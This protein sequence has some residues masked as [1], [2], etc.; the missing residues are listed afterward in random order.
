M[1]PGTCIACARL[2][3]IV[4]LNRPFLY[5]FCLGFIN[6]LI[7][8]YL[9]K[10][11]QQS[12]VNGNLFVLFE[13]LFILW[14]FR[15]WGRHLRSGKFYNIIGVTMISLWIA[16][17]VIINVLYSFNSA[18]RI[19][20]S[21]V[22]VWLSTDFLGHVLITQ[23]RTPLRDPR[24][25]ACMAFLTFFTYK[26]LFEILYLSDLPVSRSFSKIIFLIF[27]SVNLF[28]NILY[29]LVIVW[30]PTKRKFYLPY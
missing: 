27:I 12:N 18:Y 3:A 20:C 19:G 16:D 10:Q 29:T 30:M 28:C 9:I 4:S 22:L 7:S 2:P 11:H 6:E 24:V 14:L 21:L 13:F 5:F 1:L 26:L 15:N 8:L 17:N 25:I 23:K